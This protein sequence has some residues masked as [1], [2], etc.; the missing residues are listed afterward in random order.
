MNDLS[1]VGARFKELLDFGFN[2]L[3]QNELKPRVKQLCEVYQTINHRINED[4]L[5]QYES[6]DPF[7]QNFVKNIDQMLSSLKESLSSKNQ[8]IL[9]GLVASEVATQFEKNILKCNFSKYGGLHLDKEIRVLVNYLT[10]LTSWSIREKF[11]RLSQI[12]IL[13]SL[14]TLSEL[15]EYWNSPL[16][17]TWRLTPNE[18]RHILRLR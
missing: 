12:T 11:A 2:Q 9:T 3:V 1:S 7:I 5:N 16:A 13:L 10:S 4:E 17:I 15:F 8:D 14:E 18:I 6:N